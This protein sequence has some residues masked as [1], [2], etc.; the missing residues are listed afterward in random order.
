MIVRAQA[1]P[2]HDSLFGAF[3]KAI[4]LPP[5]DPPPDLERELDQAMSAAARAIADTR[6]PV[7]DQSRAYPSEVD[8]DISAH[9]YRP[10]PYRGPDRRPWFAH[11]E[12]C[13]WLPG[14]WARHS[15][16]NEARRRWRERQ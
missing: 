8:I 13:H 12:C 10:S 9:F 4:G 6:S 15:V 3:L 2:V 7:P 16:E 5:A 14:P 1:P 11:P